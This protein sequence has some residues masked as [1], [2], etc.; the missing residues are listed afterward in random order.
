MKK[1][2]KQSVY[3]FG[4]KRLVDVPT[5]EKLYEMDNRENYIRR[6]SKVK[7]ASLNELILRCTAD[8]AEVYEKTQILKCLR[9]ALQTLTKKERLLIECIYYKGLSQ[10]KTAAILM[11]AQ[12]NVSKNHDKIIKKLRSSLKD[13]L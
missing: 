2:R 10:K 8:V 7:D 11:I 13:W 9:E 3:V 12:Q 6:R 1:Y 5:D 4:R